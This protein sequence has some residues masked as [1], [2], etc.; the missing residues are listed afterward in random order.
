MTNF[1]YALRGFILVSER[2]ISPETTLSLAKSIIS[3]IATTTTQYTKMPHVYVC[4]PNISPPKP[5]P[6]SLYKLKLACLSVIKMPYAAP[7]ST[8]A[9]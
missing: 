5:M 1:E 7:K 3:P 9:M 6:T 2:E 8:A 4:A